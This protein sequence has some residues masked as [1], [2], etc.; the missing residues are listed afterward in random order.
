MASAMLVI[1]CQHCS[2]ALFVRNFVLEVFL[3]QLNV[4]RHLRGLISEAKDTIHVPKLLLTQLVSFSNVLNTSLDLWP[5]SPL[6]E[7]KAELQLI[8]RPISAEWYIGLH[9]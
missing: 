3:P 7:S 5:R 4:I 2:V 9:Y 8:R 6:R 1:L